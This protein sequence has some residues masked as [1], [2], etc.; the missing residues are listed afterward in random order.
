MKMMN[1]QENTQ[2][3]S[4][5][6]HGCI[7]GVIINRETNSA[8]FCKCRE[9]RKQENIIANSEI[10][11]AYQQYSFSNFDIKGK[12]EHIKDAKYLAMK[13]VRGFDEILKTKNNSIAFMGRSGVGKTHL[14]IA[15]AN[16]LMRSKTVPV[17]YMPYVEAITL[18]K[19][20]IIDELSYQNLISKYKRADVLVIDDLYKGNIRETDH[21]IL[22]EII[23]YRYLKR[24]PV[25][26]STE[27]Y[28]ED[29][30]DYDEAIGSRI[31]EMT[32]GMLV[33]IRGNSLNHRLG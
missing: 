14:S 33:E 9:V 26:I 2:D 1:Q 5:C 10:S 28:T 6:P 3:S 23:N 30:L 22:F 31:I 4:K 18:L 7:D 12:D 13:Y 16:N 15:I 25:I 19:Q 21:R 27:K 29:L 20:V 11:E 24:L 32:K 8:K 17:L